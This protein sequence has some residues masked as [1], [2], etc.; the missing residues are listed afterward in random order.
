MCI[1][2]WSHLEFYV[3]QLRFESFNCITVASLILCILYISCVSEIYIA[4][5][6]SFMHNYKDFEIHC[7]TQILCT[8]SMMLVLFFH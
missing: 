5:F 6:R 4:K 3:E 8:I 7:K 2:K 1:T